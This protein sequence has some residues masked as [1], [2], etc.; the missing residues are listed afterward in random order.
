MGLQ[1][2]LTAGTQTL[3]A[4][5]RLRHYW[6][7]TG[8]AAARGS[9]LDQLLLLFAG[10]PA[11]WFAQWHCQFQKSLSCAQD[12]SQQQQQQQPLLSL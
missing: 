1:D 8:F 9:L 3:Q 12:P 6:P 4:P 5:A 10:C 11:C 2:A 7:V